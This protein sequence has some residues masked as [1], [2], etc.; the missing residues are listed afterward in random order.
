MRK[1]ATGSNWNV[2][3]RRKFVQDSIARTRLLAVLRYFHV[4]LGPKFDANLAA[5]K[6]IAI[7][8]VDGASRS[9][10]VCKLRKAAALGSASVPDGE[11][12]EVEKS[13]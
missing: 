12:P 1:R 6:L 10:Y 3:G 13:A 5:A 2:V 7:E 4:A 11:K 8:L 9:V